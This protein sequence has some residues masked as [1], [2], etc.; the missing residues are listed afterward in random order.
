LE[1][2][3]HKIEDIYTVF[4]K[5]LPKRMNIPQALVTFDHFQRTYEARPDY[6]ERL[7][8]V[9]GIKVAIIIDN[10]SSMNTVIQKPTPHTR[11]SECIDAVKRS[12]AVVNCISPFGADIYFMK[13]M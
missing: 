1:Q 13:V 3:N 2:I 11:M 9:M 6:V 4:F 8:E 7:R 12:I 10:S 5:P